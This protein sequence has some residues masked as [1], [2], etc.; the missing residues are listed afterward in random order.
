MTLVDA[1]LLIYAANESA[2]EHELAIEHGLTMCS[3]DGDFVKFS[4]LTCINPM[5]G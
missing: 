3:T 5:A 2:A 1:N 4:G